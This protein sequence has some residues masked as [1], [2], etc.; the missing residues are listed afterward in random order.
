MVL[1]R[2]VF[3]LTGVLVLFWPALPSHKN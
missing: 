1:C 3:G 2:Q